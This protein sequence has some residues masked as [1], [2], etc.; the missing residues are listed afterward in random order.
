VEKKLK[1]LHITFAA[2]GEGNNDPGAVQ[3]FFTFDVWDQEHTIQYTYVLKPQGWADL[4]NHPWDPTA[5]DFCVPMT[6]DHTWILQYAPNIKQRK[7]QCHETQH[8]AVCEADAAELQ[9]EFRAIIWRADHP[10]YTGGLPPC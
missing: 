7:K 6:F 5:V 8:F 4:V 2:T 1:T 10:L 3:L 9:P